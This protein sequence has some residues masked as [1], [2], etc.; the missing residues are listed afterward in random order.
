MLS[1]ELWGQSLYE[2][3]TEIY[4]SRGRYCVVLISKHYRRKRWTQLEWRAI[5][6][7]CFSENAIYCLPV[8]LDDTELPSRG[9]QETVKSICP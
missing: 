3:L 8:R 2:Y 5:Q 1:D 9:A 4:Q 7:R 6:P